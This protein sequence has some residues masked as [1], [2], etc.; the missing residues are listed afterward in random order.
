MDA[1]VLLAPSTDTPVYGSDVTL[2]WKTVEGARGYRVQVAADEA[3]ETLVVDSRLGPVT[4]LHVRALAPGDGGRLYWRVAAKGGDYATASF[5][6]ERKAAATRAGN[7]KAVLLGGL[8]L[9][10]VAALL[11]F[12]LTPTATET[13]RRQAVADSLAADSSSTAAA[14]AASSA[15]APASDSTA[16]AAPTDSSASDSTAL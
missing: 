6:L 8:V 3:F 11:A 13:A 7:S 5:P 1:P 10:L 4:S 2:R 15:P 12:V 9:T 16:A 14:P